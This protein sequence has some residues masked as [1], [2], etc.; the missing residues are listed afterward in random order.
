[1]DADFC[2]LRN[3]HGLIAFGPFSDDGRDV[4]LPFDAAP[5]HPGRDGLFRYRLYLVV[6]YRAER[7]APPGQFRLPTY[8]LR[9]SNNDLCLRLF[10]PGYNLTKSRSDTIRVPANMVSAA[11]KE[12]PNP[13]ST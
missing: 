10:A 7:A 12:A 6:A 2:P 8:D 9:R 13:S 5:L 11:L 4:S 1:M 3:E